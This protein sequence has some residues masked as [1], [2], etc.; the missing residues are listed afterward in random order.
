MDRKKSKKKPAIKFF[1]NPQFCPHPQ[2]LPLLPLPPNP[3]SPPPPPHPAPDPPLG[4]G[5][6]RT[7][8]SSRPAGAPSCRTRMRT[9]PVP[10]GSIRR[11]PPPSPPETSTSSPEPPGTSA[12]ASLLEVGLLSPWSPPSRPLLLLLPPPPPPSPC[13]RG[14]AATP[15]LRRDPRGR[16]ER[17]RGAPARPPPWPPSRGTS[18]E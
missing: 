1:S 15:D 16:Q 11:L 14:C 4:S 10:L 13:Q 6:T 9:P 17:Q 2:H 8:A 5:K 3:P 12:A 18:T 7:S